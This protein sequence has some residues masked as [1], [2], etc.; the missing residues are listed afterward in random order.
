MTKSALRQQFLSRRRALTADDVAHRSASI[1][2]QVFQLMQPIDRLSTPGAGVIHIFLPIVRQNEVNTW[3][4]IHR[5]WREYPMV[6]IATSITNLASSQLTH[7]L[8]TPE[9]KLVENRWGIPEPQPDE[10]FRVDNSQ[11]D[12]VLIPLLVFDRRGHRVGYGK[13]Y[14]DRFLA[15][16]VPHSRKIGLSLFDPV[17]KIDDVEH[18]DVRLESCITPDR[19]YIFN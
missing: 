15:N 14:Y 11:I 19:L 10:H 8:L 16:D 6:R 3:A 5:F 18:T 1:A 7:Y 12:T 2:Q 4:I 17:D 13:G 9:T